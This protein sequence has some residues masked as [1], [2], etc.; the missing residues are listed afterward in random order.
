MI[1]ARLQLALDGG[2]LELPAEGTIAVFQP[3]RD[4]DLPGLDKDRVQIIHDFK[5]DYDAWAGRGY[6]V[7]RTIKDRYAAC[8]VCLPR[9]K[10]EARAV[11][12][13]ACEV[14]DGIVV[15]DGQ[16]TDGADSVLREMRDRVTVQ[17]P[18][19]KAHGKMF[20]ISEP[21]AEFFSDWR[22]GPELTEGG[23]WTARGSFPP[24]VSIWPRRCWWMPCP[25]SSGP[26]LPIWGPVGAFCRPT[27]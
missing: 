6:D 15:I 18:I 17:G 26:R 12:A 19:S 7:V 14:C 13:A 24:M 10:A 5:P 21:A 22:Q 9:A 20:W 1:D 3:P 11:I 2:G 8:I 27:R 25:R 4:S 16:K 23:F